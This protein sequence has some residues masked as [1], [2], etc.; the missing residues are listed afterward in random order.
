MHTLAT[1]LIKKGNAAALL[2]LYN[3]KLQHSLHSLLT[4]AERGLKQN[5]DDLHTLVESLPT[6]DR[7]QPAVYEAH[8][9]LA[10]ALRSGSRAGAQE[11]LQR[12][13]EAL[14]LNPPEP[15]IQIDTIG[16]YR[17]QEGVIQ[18]LV[19]DDVLGGMV[20]ALAP[21]ELERERA[22]CRAAMQ[23]IAAHVT[24]MDEEMASLLT[25]INLFAGTQKGHGVIGASD[26]RVFGE[27]FLRGNLY[28]MS[29]LAYYC[30]HTVH[31]TS[32]YYL[33]ALMAFD[34]MVL[35]DPAERYPAPIRQDPRPM[36]GIYHATFVLSRMVWVFDHIALATGDPA[37]AEALAT[38]REQ[39]RNGYKVVCAHGR[40]SP[41]GQQV[42]SGYSTML[43]E[44]AA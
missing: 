17:H 11:A 23:L 2:R 30:E 22:H 36:F 5:L 10:T 18:T 14:L 31:E 38:F 33:H 37:F 4:S 12:L 13:E 16:G 40:L 27:V 15:G 6:G 42:V 19:S 28:D 7:L 44:L 32:H 34:P 41:L 3:Q 26:V 43:G 9:H 29:P 24:D 8:H 25:R 35:N 20:L 1:P 39:F 21:G